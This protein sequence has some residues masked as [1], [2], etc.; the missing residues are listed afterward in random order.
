[1]GLIKI[2]NSN[3]GVRRRVVSGMPPL[4]PPHTIV[5]ERLLPRLLMNLQGNDDLP[6]RLP[7]LFNAS[8]PGLKPPK[9]PHVPH[10]LRALQS[11]RA[12][13]CFSIYN[14]TTI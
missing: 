14:C 13:P 3:H 5:V 7:K 8:I 9:Y 2:C 1:V 4:P 12:L 11:I 6:R 10:P